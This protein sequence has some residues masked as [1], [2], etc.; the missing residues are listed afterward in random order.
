M[1]KATYQ[2]QFMDLQEAGKEQLADNNN[3]G[4]EFSLDLNYA[5]EDEDIEETS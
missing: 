5:Q 3:R 2:F 4:I 1:I